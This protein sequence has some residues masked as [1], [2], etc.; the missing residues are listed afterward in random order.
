MFKKTEVAVTALASAVAEDVNEAAAFAKATVTP[1]VAGFFGSI[2]AYAEKVKQGVESGEF[3]QAVKEAVAT[4]T[5][6]S[7]VSSTP[8]EAPTEEQNTTINVLRGLGKTDEEIAEIL[9]VSIL[10]VKMASAPDE[11]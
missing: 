11:A 3:V 6:A 1:V 5:T 4:A 7:T 2:A 8:A 9:G 10:T